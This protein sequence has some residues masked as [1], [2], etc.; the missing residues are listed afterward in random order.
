[1]LPIV[2]VMCTEAYTVL[3]PSNDGPLLEEMMPHMSVHTD[4]ASAH[5]SVVSSV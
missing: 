2:F 4:F 3:W 5:P 1:M